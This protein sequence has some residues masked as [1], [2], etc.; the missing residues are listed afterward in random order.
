M[1][2]RVNVEMS[3][4]RLSE[5]SM[6]TIQYMYVVAISCLDRAASLAI[7]RCSIQLAVRTSTFDVRSG[8]PP[9]LR[10]LCRLAHTN[11]RHKFPQMLH[12]R[13]ARSPNPGVVTPHMQLLERS[14]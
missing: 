13:L 10:S 5:F 8:I 7:P 4:D 11:K 2:A 12:E 9:L 3:V 14:K 6:T 1:N